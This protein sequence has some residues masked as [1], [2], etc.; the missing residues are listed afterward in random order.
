MSGTVP[1]V[2]LRT[3]LATPVDQ[4]D[5]DSVQDYMWQALQ[6]LPSTTTITLSVGEPPEDHTLTLHLVDTEDERPHYRSHTPA[7][8]IGVDLDAIHL[9]PF[10]LTLFA[11]ETE[12]GT[13]GQAAIETAARRATTTPA[14]VTLMRQLRHY[15]VLK[16]LED[17]L[18]L[19]TQ[20]RH[21]PRVRDALHTNM[22]RELLDLTLNAPHLTADQAKLAATLA[23]DWSGTPIELLET[24]A[25]L[26]ST[27]L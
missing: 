10:G 21:N 12:T 18:N 3:L 27:P 11:D 14:V 15:T 5:L 24:V 19:R 4:L 22:R 25:A 1:R 9:D 16:D 17:S 13:P 23:A 8:M 2:D 7:G 20:Y 6:A 26:T